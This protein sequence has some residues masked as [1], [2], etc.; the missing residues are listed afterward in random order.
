MEFEQILKSDSGNRED[1][2]GTVVFDLL[3]SYQKIRDL[4]QTGMSSFASAIVL[5]G[6]TFWSNRHREY[7]VVGCEN[8]SKEGDRGNT[9]NPLCGFFFNV[10][11]FRCDLNSRQKH[12][13][14]NADCIPTII[15]DNR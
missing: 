12:H 8:R 2:I 5:W 7:Y 9:Y 11:K 6:R 4:E 3:F 14:L 15:N 10:G 1:E 13:Y